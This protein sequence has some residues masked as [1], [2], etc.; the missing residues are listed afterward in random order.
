M[1]KMKLHHLQ[2][3]DAW[4]EECGFYAL[5]QKDFLPHFNTLI[6]N[7]VPLDLAMQVL[8]GMVDLMRFETSQMGKL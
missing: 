5:A 3:F 6:E 2:Q 8:A 1:S 7:G 4:F